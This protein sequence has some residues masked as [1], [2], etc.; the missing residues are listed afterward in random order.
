MGLSH[1]HTKFHCFICLLLWLQ[2]ASAELQTS[3]SRLITKP[4]CQDVCGNVSIPYPFGIGEGCHIDNEEFKLICN[5]SYINSTKLMYGGI[6]VSNISVQDGHLTVDVYISTDCSDKNIP[7]LNPAWAQLGNFTFSNT[8]NKFIAIGCD[9]YAFLSL[10]DKQDYRSLACTSSCNT[11]KDVTDM[12]C[13]GNGCCELSIPP[14]LD[15]YNAM[16]GSLYRPRRNLDFN[17][18][19]YAFLVEETSFKFSKSYLTNFKNYGSGMVPVVVDW[20]VGSETCE[21]AET[22]LTSYACGPNS[23]CISSEIPSISGYRCKCKSGYEGNP[24]LNTS[25]GGECQGNI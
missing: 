11:M 25:S 10:G 18:C 8:K 1:V 7:V 24:Y 3:V 19:S 5:D 23:V 15:L 13:T 21:E 6:N 9:T 22:N 2:V 16:V 14:G 17:P 20:T 12:S 4:G